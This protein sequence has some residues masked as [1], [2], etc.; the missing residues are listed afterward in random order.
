MIDANELK[1]AAFEDL[2]ESTFSGFSDSQKAALALLL[3]SVSEEVLVATSMYLGL[4]WRMN[5]R[6]K[7][8]LKRVEAWGND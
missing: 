4:G 8:E 7:G 3:D 2:E 6:I 5:E 1:R